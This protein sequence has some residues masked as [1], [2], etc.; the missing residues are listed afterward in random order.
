[1]NKKILAVV[2]LLVATLAFAADKYISSSGN[3][4]LKPGRIQ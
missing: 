4:I 1:M 2:L 3:I